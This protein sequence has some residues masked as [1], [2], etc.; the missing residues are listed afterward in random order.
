MPTAAARPV[1]IAEF[2]LSQVVALF[3]FADGL[4]AALNV[5]AGV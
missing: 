2:W 4:A 3:M 5:G 1:S